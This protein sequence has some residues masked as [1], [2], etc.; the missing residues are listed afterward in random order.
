M[1]FQIKTQEI[2]E[3]FFKKKSKEKPFKC[4]LL[5]RTEIRTGDS[6]SNLRILSYFRLMK[7][8]DN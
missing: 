5:A 1:L 3:L 2:R 4:A 6:Q 8:P 7:F